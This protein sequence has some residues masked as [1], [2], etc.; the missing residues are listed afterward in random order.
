MRFDKVIIALAA[1]ALLLLALGAKDERLKI[2]VFDADRALSTTKEGK[3]ASEEFDRKRR[4]AEAQLAP[5]VERYQE[6]GK[7][8]E[9]KK[10]V[11]SEEA[12]FQKQLDVAELRNQIENKQKEIQG[13]LEVD[14]E[15]L[16]TPIFQKMQEVVQ[17]YGRDQ[18][19]SL[20]LLRNSPGLMYVREALDVTD[21]I[22]EQLD[23]KG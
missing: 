17:K 23:K 8:L 3:A 18:D 21:Q 2:G 7:E 14:R 20:I 4:A 13:Q 10:F 12:R 19:F 5:L 22:I 16:L 11:L 9:A 15:R 1:L 6:T